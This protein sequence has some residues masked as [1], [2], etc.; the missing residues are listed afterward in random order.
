MSDIFGKKL[1]QYML[2]EQLGEGGM[3]KV[4]NALDERIEKNVAIKVI[5]PNKRSSQV[6]LQQFDLEAKSLAKLTHTNIVKV[7]NYG[8]D[9]GQPYL[10]MEFVPGGTL[11]ESVIGRLPWQKAAEILAPIARALDYVHNSKI[12]HQDIKP[13]NILVD[14]EFRPMLSDFGVVKLLE[15]KEGENDAIGV[16]VGTPDYMSPEQ[17]MG[18]NV[19]FRT[20]IYSLGVVFYELMTG[21]KPFIADTPMAVVIKHVTDEF[22]LPRK[23]DQ[24]IPQFVENAIMRAVQKDPDDR[25]TSM[26][27]FADVLEL[28]ALGEKAPRKKILSL[29]RKNKP[30]KK[31]FLLAGLPA[32]LILGI[33]IFFFG[34][35][36]D[37]FNRLTGQSVR[38]PQTELVATPAISASILVNPSATISVSS[39]TEVAVTPMPQSDPELSATST[40]VLVQNQDASVSLLG[41]PIPSNRSPFVEIARWGIGGVN[42][43]IW[44][45]NGDMIA[46]GTTSGIFLYDSQ[47]NSLKRFINPDFNVISL[48]FNVD[49]S[50]ILAGSPDGQ[51]KAWYTDTGQLN[52]VY[53]KNNSA[54]NSLSLSK[55][56]KNIVVGYDNGDFIVHPIDQDRAIMTGSLYPSIRSVVS[57]ADERFL[58]VSNGTKSVYLWDIGTQK[59]VSETLEH[60]TPINKLVISTDRQFLLSAGDNNIAYLWDLAE[61]RLVIGFG[62]LGGKVTDMDFS[63]DASLVVIG[64]D[65]GQVKVFDKPDIKD[66][67]KAQVPI[68][69]IDISLDTLRSISFSPNKLVIA[70][71]NWSDGLKIWDVVTGE[72]I[73]SLDNSMS[74]ITKLEFS[75][76]AAWLATAHEGSVVRVWDVKEAKQAYIFDGSLSKGVSFSPNSQFLAIIK[77][78]KNN[79]YLTSIQIVELT[80]GQIVSEM[81]GYEPNS[82]LQFS[83]DS[84]LLVTGTP[85]RAVIWDVSSWEKVDSHGG[86]VNEGCGKFLTPENKLLTVISSVGILFNSSPTDEKMCGTSPKGVTF[87]Y[88]FQK[89]ARMAFVK[90]DGK[91]WTWDFMSPDIS[92]LDPRL[93]YPNP[94]DIFL[95]GNQESG[96]YA[97]V[98][99][100]SLFIKD[101]SGKSYGTILG[102]DDYDYQVAFLPTQKMFALGS[103][104]GSIHFWTLP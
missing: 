79:Q 50:Q 5:L 74:G 3:A 27:Q 26:G 23:I 93:I 83:S 95:S 41:T 59:Q 20:D 57:S 53:T 16:G 35:N 48:A 4:Y 91:I 37:L 68:L 97:S 64:L 28:I 61:M 43:V 80:S 44:S 21:E 13:S 99:G 78:K 54:V 88:Y 22:P 42:K 69:T 32:I 36:F 100:P 62:N 9:D 84:K 25:Y 33:V 24:K 10:V 103:K 55:N 14:E 85:N 94:S 29:T 19:D 15:A 77:N 87:V 67:S 45:P 40:Q 6:F 46:L 86:R 51:L 7:L 104:Y 73:S 65:N 76:N 63:P 1:G 66:Y 89:Q 30:Q 102:H 31:S 81:F 8:T 92:K 72:K 58:Y 98:A 56:K 75:P 11:K 70:S 38:K 101:I 17:G 71:G 12:V 90:G 60:Q 82:F 34:L 52:H 39:T 49:G 18:K 2:L 96:L 47:N